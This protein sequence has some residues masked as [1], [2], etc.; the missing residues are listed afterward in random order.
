ML[1]AAF[2][3]EEVPAGPLGFVAWI[4]TNWTALEANGRY[5]AGRLAAPGRQWLDL[6]R[7]GDGS[8]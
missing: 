1:V 4:D 7:E 8:A 3:R 5:R 6:E 2:G